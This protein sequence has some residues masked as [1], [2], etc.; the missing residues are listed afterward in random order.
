MSDASRPAPPGP[1][2]R[3]PVRSFVRRDGRLT[4]GQQ[5]ALD[6]HYHQQRFGVPN[7]DLSST[8]TSTDPIDLKQLFSGCTQAVLE[9]GFGNGESL[10]AQAQAEPDCG[11]LGVEVHRPG[12]GH[13][14]NRLNEL[15]LNNVRVVCQDA[16]EVVGQRLPATTLDRVQVFFPDPWPKTRHHKR[17][18]IQPDFVA[19]LTSRLKP[20]GLLHL[21]T[22]WQPY[23]EHM[24]T[25][26]NAAAKLRNTADADGY[27]PRPDHRP[28]TKF[29]RRGLARGHGVYDLIFERA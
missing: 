1:E 21:A 20:G 28:L 4:P 16:V 19:L 13:L 15:E 10:L 6:N 7:S 27:A 29:E 8:Q 17:R 12:V 18:L 14:L 23:A 2:Q 26:L 3:R 11:F 9:I 22:D 25:T 24:L 5:R